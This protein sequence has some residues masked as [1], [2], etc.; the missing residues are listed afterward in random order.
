MVLPLDPNDP[1]AEER[2]RRAVEDAGQ[3]R[4]ARALAETRAELDALILDGALTPGEMQ[5]LLDRYGNRFDEVMAEAMRRAGR[6]A[7]SVELQEAHRYAIGRTIEEGAE[8]GLS[9]AFGQL[10]NVGIN[11]SY[12]PVNRFAVEWAQ[13]YTFDLVSRID[14][15]TGRQLGNAVAGWIQRGDA[16]PSLV[17]DLEP[18]FG[19]VRAEMIASTETTRAF[20]E[21]SLIGYRQTP[22]VVGVE[23]LTAAD[24]RVCPICRPL[25]GERGNMEGQFV[26]PGGE[27]NA[28]RYEGRTFIV[29]CHVRCRC[30]LAPIVDTVMVANILRINEALR[31]PYPQP[32]WGKQL[33]LRPASLEIY[34]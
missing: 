19:P 23:F 22:V 34:R 5:A 1:E 17:R 18:L 2:A 20:A 10:G 7:R 16:L 6:E 21:G 26:H 11:L 25:N 15:S 3:R 13:Q 33:Y 12:G 4:I 30:R 8:A 14:E 32:S 27:G 28:T 24:E 29:P 31:G 9:V